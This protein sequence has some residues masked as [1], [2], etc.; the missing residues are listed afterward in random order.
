MKKKRRDRNLPG[1]FAAVLLLTVFFPRAMAAQEPAISAE[2]AVVMDF[3]TGEFYY[4]KNADLPRPVASMTKLMSLYLVFEEMEAGN[5]SPDSLIAAGARAA[6]ISNNSLYSGLERLQAGENYRVEDLIRI[7]MTKSCNGSVLALAEHIGGTEEAFVKRMNETAARW[8]LN[9]RFADSFG[10]QDDGNAVS[11]RSMAILAQRLIADYPQI[12]DYSSLPETVFQDRSFLSTNTLLR[13]GMVEGIDGLKTGTTDGAGHCFTGTAQREGRRIIS[14]VMGASGHTARMLESQ[15]LLEYGF[16]CRQVRE[17][18]WNA[19]RESFHAD[20]AARSPLRANTEVILT[21]A[22]SRLTA[23]AGGQVH[24]EV[25]GLPVEG[26]ERA[27]WLMNGATAE[28]SVLVP[29]GDEPLS[30]ALVVTLPDGTVLR[31]EAQLPRDEGEVTF[32]GRMGVRRLELYPETSFRVPFQIRCDQEV[33]SVTPAGWYLDGE[34]IPFFQNAAFRVGP[35]GRRSG[36]NLFGGELSPGEHL[37]EFRLNPEGLPGV[38]QASFPLE[39]LI[40]E[41]P[42]DIF[43][44]NPE[45]EAA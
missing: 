2:G 11:P 8:G 21:A 19:I 3:D 9:A 38:E 20:L 35:E 33:Y 32:T 23:E 43:T 6:A 28:T 5:L 4:E 12:L 30:A 14:V 41:D 25:E 45:G 17:D 15:T 39:L 22:L 27:L 24:W 40:L 13:E 10:F 42:E 44:H 29:A 36:Y 31:Q 34:P 16:A 18:A 7:I 1:L 37:L 26:S